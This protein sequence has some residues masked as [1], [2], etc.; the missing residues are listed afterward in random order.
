[1]APLSLCVE[2]RT[3]RDTHNREITLRGINVA[4][5]AKYPKIPDIPSY[6]AEKFF[7]A[8]NVSFVGR[9]FPLEDAHIHFQKLRKWGY[10]TI[11]YIFTWEAI[12]HAGPGIY[13]QEWI[14]FTI[15]VL[16]IAKQYEFYVFMDPHQDVVGHADQI[17]YYDMLTSPSGPGF[18]GV[19]EHL[20]GRSMRQ[21]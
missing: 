8:D 3:F 2:G 14:E 4:A 9:P 11:R 19:P 15:E 13:D 5:D 10:N 12:E 1:M 16:R 7:D 17:H 18:Q 21:V 6:V 20:C